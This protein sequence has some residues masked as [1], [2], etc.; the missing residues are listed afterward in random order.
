MAILSRGEV[1]ATLPRRKREAGQTQAF[2]VGAWVGRRYVGWPS[3]RLDV[4]PEALTLRFRPRLGSKIRTAPKP[5][6]ERVQVWRRWFRYWVSVEDSQGVFKGISLEIPYG[7]NRLI[8][9]LNAQGYPG[10]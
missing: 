1:L 5:T 8:S 9:E 6:V 4:S 10:Y 2:T 7:L 3:G